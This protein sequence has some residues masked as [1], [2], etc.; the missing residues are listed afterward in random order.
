M[1][2][3]RPCKSN[4]HLSFRSNLHAQ[5]W[6]KAVCHRQPL[7]SSQMWNFYVT[8]RCFARG[9]TKIKLERITRVIMYNWQP[10]I[11]AV[12]STVATIIDCL[13][14]NQMCLSCNWR[15]IL[16]SKECGCEC[17]LA[18][19]TKSRKSHLNHSL[20]LF[21]PNCKR[22]ANV[23]PF[24][25]AYAKSFFYFV[26]SVYVWNEMRG[27]RSLNCKDHMTGS[28]RS[29]YARKTRTNR[30]DCRTSKRQALSGHTFL[31]YFYGKNIPRNTQFMMTVIWDLSYY[32]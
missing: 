4:R 14:S 27:V 22:I 7:P 9:T 23:L 26:Y 28:G 3:F 5:K 8:S 18:N 19:F 6:K 11:L 13:S 24:A 12:A 17:K 30:L 1:G 16:T 10:K 25:E 20:T 31:L 29:S 32:S 21:S 2:D 15:R